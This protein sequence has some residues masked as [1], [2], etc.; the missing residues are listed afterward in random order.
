MVKVKNKKI[1]SKV[2]EKK[3][4]KGQLRSGKNYQEV[5]D[6]NYYESYLRLFKAHVRIFEKK[7]SFIYIG[8]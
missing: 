2:K 6:R 4:G 5:N 3:R 7:P 1:R 8:N